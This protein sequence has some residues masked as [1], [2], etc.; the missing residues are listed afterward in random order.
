MR[1]SPSATDALFAGAAGFAHRG[2][3]GPGVPENS[4][5]AFE[6]A[7][8][9]GAGIECDLRL[10]RDGFA[11]VFHDCDL[12]RL[13]DLPV[14]TES[15]HA[16]ALMR[17]RL[18]GSDQTIPWL[19]ALLDR[20]GGRVPLLLELKAR[21]EHPINPLCEA[22]AKTLAIYRGAVGVMSF[23]PR[24]PCWFARN[25]PGIP[26]GLVVGDGIGGLRR[27]GMLR[28]AKPDFLAVETH[29][30]RRPWVARERRRCPVA[31]WT[32]RSAEQRAALSDRADALIWEADGRP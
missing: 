18:G 19:G 30:A 12:A 10:S 29:A 16:A 1:S 7:I 26:R 15:L 3:H 11:M 28:I 27:W 14:E 31:S 21:A 23:D 2:L 22:V 24:A 4:M 17:L 20:V 6:A 25:A 32:V 13:C 5:A 8:E 9:A